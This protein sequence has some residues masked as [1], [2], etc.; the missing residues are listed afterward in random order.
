MKE[1]R[2][3]FWRWVVLGIIL[4]I[5]LVA[6]CQSDVP[7]G[8]T[9]AEAGKPTFGEALSANWE[10]LIFGTIIVVTGVMI[11]VALASAAETM[12]DPN[13]RRLLA[14]WLRRGKAE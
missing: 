14:R 12:S 2:E 9:R 10:H 1:E 11:G 6:W 5:P 8:A 13:F 7:E 3:R 4:A